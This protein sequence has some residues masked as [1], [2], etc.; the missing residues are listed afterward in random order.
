MTAERGKGLMGYGLPKIAKA[1]YRRL[2]TSLQNASPGGSGRR[3]INLN[4]VASS[5]R[6]MISRSD[7]C[8]T[9]REDVSVQRCKPRL[10]TAAQRRGSVFKPSPR[11]AH[12]WSY[13]SC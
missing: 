13:K 11:T 7:S 9:Q 2:S 3:W 10:C 5:R 12:G 6:G 1:Q 4:S 8:L